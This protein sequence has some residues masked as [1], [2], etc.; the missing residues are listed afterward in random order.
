MNTNAL[1]FNQRYF[2]PSPTPSFYFKVRT[3]SYCMKLSITAPSIP[4][5]PSAFLMRLATSC[6]LNTDI[7]MVLLMLLKECLTISFRNRAFLLAHSQ[8]SFAIRFADMA[9]LWF[10][11]SKVPMLPAKDEQGLHNKTKARDRA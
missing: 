10:L 5:C 8:S 9:P 4:P 7:E 6:A 1:P 3:D 2:P 11:D